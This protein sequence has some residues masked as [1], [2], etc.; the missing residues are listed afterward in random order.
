MPRDEARLQPTLRRFRAVGVDVGLNKAVVQI[1]HSSGPLLQREG[2]SQ[3][4]L[5]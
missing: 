1:A 5:Y 2:E 4:N 3:S